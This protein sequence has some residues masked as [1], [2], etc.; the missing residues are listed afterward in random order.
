VEYGLKH[1]WNLCGVWWIFARQSRILCIKWN[2]Q[3]VWDREVLEKCAFIAGL[4]DVFWLK[5]SV[6]HYKLAILA[7]SKYKKP[8]HSYICSSQ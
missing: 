1:V 5:V 6:S 7:N 3:F 2:P 8:A 4:A